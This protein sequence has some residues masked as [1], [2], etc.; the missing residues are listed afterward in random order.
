[1]G[2][3][4]A[5]RVFDGDRLIVRDGAGRET[6]LRLFGIDAPDRGQAY[7]DKASQGLRLLLHEHWLRMEVV[8]TDDFGRTF[9]MLYRNGDGESVNSHMVRQGLAWGYPRDD[10]DAAMLALEKRAR[11]ERLGLWGTSLPPE[12]PWEWR[13]QQRR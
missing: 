1:M 12:P 11:K 6:E 8:E 9:A 3:L 5:V 4:T 2:T 13:Q 10:Q 7:S